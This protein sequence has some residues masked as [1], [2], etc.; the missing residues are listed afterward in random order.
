[1]IHR[2][3]PGSPVPWPS[4]PPVA[5]QAQKNH[6][7]A[8]AGPPQLNPAAEHIGGYLRIAADKRWLQTV[9]QFRPGTARNAEY[10][11]RVNRQLAFA[12]PHRTPYS[13]CAIRCERSHAA[14]GYLRIFGV[15]ARA[16]FQVGV[17]L[18]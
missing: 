13:G 16:G 5:G 12:G 4:A 18:L 2:R 15:P 9:I 14:A 7:C 11:L 10:A 6:I 1:V 3:E 17:R 8:A